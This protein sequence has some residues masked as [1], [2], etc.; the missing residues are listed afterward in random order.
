MER[1]KEYC[2]RCKKELMT[3]EIGLTKKLVNRGS[4][5]YYCLDCL[6]D[7]FEVDRADLEKKI[8]YFKDMG[9]TLFPQG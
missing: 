2:R 1:D 9:C 4:E 8:Q 5:T 7:S 6:A 3:D